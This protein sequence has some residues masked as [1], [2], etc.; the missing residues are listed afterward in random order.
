MAFDIRSLALLLCLSAFV[1]AILLGIQFL[2]YRS[3]EGLGRWSLGSLLLALGFF[4]NYLRA[5]PSLGPLAVVGNTVLFVAG[6]GLILSGVRRFLDLPSRDLGP[7]LL[8]LLVA[9]LG[10]FFTYLNDS[11]AARRINLSMAVALLSFLIGR[12]LLGQPAGK[13]RWA[14]GLLAAIFFFHSFFWTLRGLTPLFGPTGDLFEASLIQV[15]TYL[16]TLA[17]STFWTFGFSLLVILRLRSRMEEDLES[18]TVIFDTSP[19]ALSIM[20][21]QD[22]VYTEI[23]EG[24][25]K[26]SGYT[27]EE[28]RGKRN[29]DLRLWKRKED[30]LALLEKLVES[31]HC[32]GLEAA[33]TRKDGSTLVGLVSARVVKLRGRA[34]IISV[35]HDITARKAAEAKIQDLVHQLEIERNYAQKSARTDGLTRLDNRKSFDET[36]NT[37]FFRHKRSRV[38]LSVIML[39]IDHFK[40][41]NDHFGHV[42]GDDCLRRVA[43]ALQTSVGRL[44]DTVS[45]F[46]G[47]EFAVILPE[48]DYPGAA[49]VAER[50]RK[51][52]EALQIP[53]APGQTLPWVTISLG[54]ASVCPSAVASPEEIVRLADSALY[55]AKKGGRNRIALCE[56]GLDR[57]EG[58]PGKVLGL[59]Q[60][61]WNLNYECGNEVIDGQHQGLF[62]TS[63]RLLAAFAGG[64]PK[65]ECQALL[66]SLLE[67]ILAHFRDEEV[68]LA[69]LGF[70][71]AAGHGMLH[72]ELVAKATALAGK[73]D[74]GALPFSELVAFLAIDV[75]S[76]HLFL[77]DRKYFPYIQ[78][79]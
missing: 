61:A 16:E 59:V 66:A 32:E 36:L 70:P 65:E 54:V 31:G 76:Q 45:R 56:D 78:P 60:L 24:F 4:L 37:E 75:V 64:R 3:R 53:H 25:A 27:P 11:A 77:E 8:C 57:G 58:R 14:Q 12:T 34:H 55:Q 35:T 44:P 68:L 48:T 72:T 26:L 73:F 15:L 67:D 38:P 74:A 42:A 23:N 47:E 18:R 2:G 1:Q 63:N 9:L 10:L 33:F 40:N 52:V 43:A 13:E 28:I 79:A 39:D 30:R 41:Y 71:D 22:G 7:I 51:S 20:R 50:L 17:A 62:S 6:L 29:R 49:T 46:G 69:Q 5:N 19:D 21:M